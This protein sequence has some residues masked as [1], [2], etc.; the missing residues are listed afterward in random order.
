MKENI[1]LGKT[2]LS[3][4]DNI[5]VKKF[6]KGLE[7]GRT[8]YVPADTDV[9]TSSESEGVTTTVETKVETPEVIKSGH[10]I[11][12]LSDGNYQ[13]LPIK[14]VITTVGTGDPTEVVSYD[15]LPDGASYAGL[16]YKDVLKIL[17]AASIMTWGIVNGIAMANATAFASIKSA[18]Q[19]AVPFIDYQIDE[20]A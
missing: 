15:S 2:K 3:G 19:A 16:L 4:F 18:F 13:A 9:V 10:V 8:L 6:I 17:P 20:E 12:Q 7:G 11:I 1:V 14:R 5:V